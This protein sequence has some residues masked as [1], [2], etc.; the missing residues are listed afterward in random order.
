M[1]DGEDEKPI[2]MG[3]GDEETVVRVRGLPWSATVE[4]VVKFFDGVNIKNGR[5]G[6][7]LTLSR[8]GRPS[9]EAYVEVSS[10]EDV[11][12]AEKKHNQ[13]MGRRYI[14]V[15][16]AK[17]SEMEWVVKRA[18]FGASGGEDDGCVRL[19]GLP[20]GC[21]KEEIA[22]F[23]SGLEIVPNGIALPTD[24][25][26][27]HTGEAYVQ[28]INKEVA[29]K[30]LEKHKEKIAH[31][32]IE[33][34]R[35]NLGEVRAA[36]SPKMRGP[37]GPMGGYNN[38][39][40]PYDSR[41]RFGGMNRYSLGGR[42]RTR[43]Y[44]DYDDGPGWGGSGGYNDGPSSWLSGRGGR[45]G[46]PGGLKGNFGGGR[47]GSWNNGTGHCVHMRGLPFRATEMDIADF[48]R[49]LNPVNINIIMDSS[50]RPSGEADIE[51]A[52]HDDA[53]KA[54]SKDKANMQ[55]RYIELFLNST[56]G[57]N[58]GGPGGPMGGPVGP[59]GGPGSGNFGGGGGGNFSGGNMGGGFGGG[60][61]GGSRMGGGGSGYGSGMGGGGGGYS[62]LDEGL[63]SGMGSGGGGGGGGMG[64]G[65]SEWVVVVEAEWV[66]VVEAEWV[67]A[68]AEWVAAAAEWAE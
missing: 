18:G 30:S 37:G 40:T 62:S 9:G 48:F 59:M 44:N 54:M 3:E 1:S 39:P 19:R 68:A 38:R 51:F 13:H 36:M 45:G 23:F 8:E 16:K 11:T 21:S 55:H 66:V 64:G 22:Q 53:V 60:Y 61:G 24:Y 50:N 65:G 7:H 2:K 35:S 5:D 41:D 10:E 63:G 58:M 29:E 12:L 15:F 20:F 57:G 47:G 31:R 33:I 27:R 56:P 26:G 14:E 46:G 43:G 49:P 42:G 28:F 6:V 17:K 67:A 25:Q 4:D 52:T 32:Y 34:F